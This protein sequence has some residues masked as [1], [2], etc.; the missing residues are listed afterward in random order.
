MANRFAAQ[1]HLPASLISVSGLIAV[2]FLAT[3]CI[4]SQRTHQQRLPNWDAQHGPSTVFRGP[5]MV[6]RPVLR[7][8]AFRPVPWQPTSE[9]TGSASGPDL[10]TCE[11]SK[12]CSQI[13]K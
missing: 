4:S 3:A 11:A 8:A 10:G 13:P 9:D 7:L 2:L 5:A 1:I 6:R 12:S